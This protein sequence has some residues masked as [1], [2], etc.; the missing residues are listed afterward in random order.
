MKMDDC[1]ACRF[2]HVDSEV[3]VAECALLPHWPMA[4]DTAPP[5]NKPIRPP[6]ECPI[7]QGKACPHCGGKAGRG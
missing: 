5:Y 6:L 7:N 2:Y 4:V 3:M 1:K